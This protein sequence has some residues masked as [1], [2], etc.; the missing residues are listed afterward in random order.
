M[1]VNLTRSRRQSE[2]LADETERRWQVLHGTSNLPAT[3]QRAPAFRQE[4]ADALRANTLLLDRQTHLSNRPFEQ[5][6]VLLMRNPVSMEQAYRVLGY[7]LGLFPPAAI[8]FR[9]F[10]YGITTPP[11]IEFSLGLFFFCL[12]MNLICCFVGGPMGRFVGRALFNKDPNSWNRRALRSLAYALI[13]ALVTGATGGA[14]FFGVGAY[15]GFACAVPVALLA[16][17]LFTLVHATVLKDGMI[18]SGQLWPIASGVSLLVATM[19]L[20]LHV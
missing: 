14:I 11:R 19:I 5:D 2:W 10:H 1:Y 17:P 4:R 20:S 12:I 13:W 15:F 8:F 7:L 6:C 18:E 9:I 16:F 3:N